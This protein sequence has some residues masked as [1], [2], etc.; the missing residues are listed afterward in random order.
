[1]VNRLNLKVSKNGFTR[2]I[3]LYIMITPFLIAFC[4][5]TVIPIFSSIVL[6]FF[7]YDMVGKFDFV[8]VDNYFRMIM[9]DDVFPTSQCLEQLINHYTS[10]DRTGI[11]CPK[12]LMD[13]RLFISET[14]KQ[15]LSNPFKYIYEDCLKEELLN[16][17]ETVEIEGMA[18]EGP[19]IR[20]EV[21]ESIGLPN[22]DLFILYDDTEYS[23]RA[24]LAGYKVK[25]VSSAVM[26]KYNHQSTL[27][28]RDNLVKNK[29][30]L[31]YHFRNTAYFC[32]KYGK[33]MFF[34][35]FGTLPFVLDMYAAIT[36][37]FFKGHKYSISDYF[38]IL[39]MIRRGIK[40]EL[41]KM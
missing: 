25:V 29:W 8:G 11:L 40:G 2:K 19:L 15:N 37:N 34:Q 22:K 10:E 35:Y 32:H 27:T 21:V 39:K 7:S 26:E 36:Y 1:M 12:R 3:P 5:F 17:N 6:S 13:G 20:C 18:F 24:I 30:K 38:M 9:D 33:N 31:K 14:R 4:I 28:K 23:Y 16:N 41:G